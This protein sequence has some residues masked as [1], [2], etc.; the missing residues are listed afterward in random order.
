MNQ[1]S[2]IFQQDFLQNITPVTTAQTDRRFMI[3]EVTE[4]G[5]ALQ[6]VG[7]DPELQ[8]PKFR[9]FRAPISKQDAEKLHLDNSALEH[10]HLYKPSQQKFNIPNIKHNDEDFH[11]AGDIIRYRQTNPNEFMHRM[12]AA[13]F[14][15]R[16][17]ITQSVTKSSR[18]QEI[19][20][21]R[22]VSTVSLMGNYRTAR[23]PLA[24][25]FKNAQEAAN[26]YTQVKTTGISPELMEEARKRDLKNPNR[27]LLF[28][29]T[30]EKPWAVRDYEKEQ[31]LG[32]T[33]WKEIKCPFYNLTPEQT[34]IVDDPACLPAWLSNHYSTIITK[35]KERKIR[36]PLTSGQNTL[37]QGATAR[38]V[39]GL[40]YTFRMLHTTMVQNRALVEEICR[41]RNL[42][43]EDSKLLILNI[44]REAG[45]N[46][47]SF[48]M[49][50]SRMDA[51]LGQIITH[52]LSP[53]PSNNVN[54][55]STYKQL[56]K[57]WPVHD[58]GTIHDQKAP[59]MYNSQIL[60][61]SETTKS[62]AQLTSLMLHKDR[63]FLK[64]FSPYKP[65]Q[66]QKNP[67]STGEPCVT[68][69]PQ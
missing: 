40:A 67:P 54:C 7:N 63:T 56:E 3:Q 38:I 57:A 15:Q 58:L 17:I 66:N 51:P 46:L 69:P 22:D 8:Q 14:A 60:E 65:E 19:Q 47:V 32:G 16:Q 39:E 49:M 37:M 28:Y 18:R 11:A 55:I 31:R 41:P 61:T 5:E 6:T 9:T 26:Y 62:T 1:R 64:K 50:L 30:L 29:D 44:E 4:T 27:Q 20:T 33:H 36:E 34:R 42:S 23:E 25:H 45:K 43:P 21:N 48:N 2:R 35:E 53:K 13:N 24:P 59:H 52:L 68:T 10:T 12:Q